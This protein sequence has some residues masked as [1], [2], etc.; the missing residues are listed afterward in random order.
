MVVHGLKWVLRDL[1]PNWCAEGLWP[2]LGPR[3]WWPIVVW[4]PPG[5]PLWPHWIRP[6]GPN[7]PADHGPWTVNHAPRAVGAVGRLNGPERP[8]RPKPP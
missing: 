5:C 6:K 8:F 1:W 7:W 4:D 3:D 2:I